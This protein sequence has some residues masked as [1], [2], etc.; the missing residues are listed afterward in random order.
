MAARSAIRQ[1]RSRDCTTSGCAVPRRGELHVAPVGRDRY[2]RM[3]CRCVR[4]RPTRCRAAARGAKIPTIRA[5]A[6]RSKLQL[7][8]FHS[9]L[10]A[11]MDRPKAEE[12][13][14]YR[15]RGSVVSA[16]GHVIT[17]LAGQCAPCSQHEKNR[18]DKVDPVRTSAQPAHYARSRIQG[19]DQIRV[20]T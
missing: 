4:R 13:R 10:T 17:N 6:D 1:E 19:R 3:V 11:A 2:R 18:A 8:Q 14:R 16:A 15:D 20:S 7:L 9:N 5:G 12:T